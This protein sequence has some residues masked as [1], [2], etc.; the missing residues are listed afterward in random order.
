MKKILILFV[1]LFC[2]IFLKTPFSLCFLSQNYDATHTFYA[3]QNVQ[4]QNAT[5][6]QNG[7]GFLISTN[8]QNAT[9]ILADINAH[10]IQGESFCFNGNA[11]DAQNILHSLNAKIM[12]QE[13]FEDFKVFYAYSPKLEK[14]VL[15]NLQKINI[16]IAMKNGKITVGSPIILGGF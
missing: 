9:E 16:Q 15:I 12:T 14:Y 5:V 4:N 6:I 7:N 1:F 3:T 2:L 13:C 10:N 8:S 11:D